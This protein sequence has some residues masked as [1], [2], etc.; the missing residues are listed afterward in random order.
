MSFANEDVVN[1][2]NHLMKFNKYL[3]KDHLD[4]FLNGNDTDFNSLTLVEKKKIFTDHSFIILTNKI[5]KYEIIL[6]FTLTG[7]FDLL[8]YL[9]E[10]DW[11]FNF[12]YK[13]FTYPNMAVIFSKSLKEIKFYFEELKLDF[14]YS[15]KG[16]VYNNNFGKFEID[17]NDLLYDS[18]INNLT[19][20]EGMEMFKYIFEKVVEKN[21]KS[22]INS[23]ILF[24]IINCSNIEFIE[25]V[26]ERFS[27]DI[28]KINS[29]TRISPLMMA[30]ERCNLETIKY[31]DEKYDF[32]L[33][34]KIKR[35]TYIQEVI[36]NLLF[37]Y[38]NIENIN[39][40][41]F[42]EEER[43]KVL[44]YIITS[45]DKEIIDDYLENIIENLQHHPICKLLITVIKKRELI[46]K[47]KIEPICHYTKKP[48]D[49]SKIDYFYI[50]KK[51][52]YI[53]NAEYFINPDDFKNKDIIKIYINDCICIDSEIKKYFIFSCGHM[54]C[55]DCIINLINS[56]KNCSFCRKEYE[57]I[58]YVEF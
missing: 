50:N 39:N 7:Q 12:Y 34:K 47:H 3:V 40:Y 57:I 31:F 48:I 25:E 17:K 18:C 15:I 41:I 45:F 55:S 46:L 38:I 4:L 13:D 28:F 5:E 52:K 6:Y 27:L 10:L 26:T 51:D 42:D 43:I 29:I 1:T 37:N 56:T 35:D 14:D 20:P 2:E 53:F 9:K 54:I 30:F 23:N 44:E 33:L 8:L 16:F 32:N 49:K 22:A 11:D 21:P 24:N 58:G 19:Y 36:L